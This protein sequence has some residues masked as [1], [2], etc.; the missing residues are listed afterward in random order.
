MD[1]MKHS[2]SRQRQTSELL[3]WIW[4]A[5]YLNEFFS[6]EGMIPKTERHVRKYQSTVH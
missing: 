5:A 1:W 4:H 6:C 2:V 3:I